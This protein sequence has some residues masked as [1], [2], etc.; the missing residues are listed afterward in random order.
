M[1]QR[2][3]IKDIEKGLSTDVIIAN[4]LNKRTDNADGILKIIRAYKWQQRVKYGRKL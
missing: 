2:K 4:Y 1:H 3:I